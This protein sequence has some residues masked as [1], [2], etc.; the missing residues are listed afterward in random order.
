MD[1]DEIVDNAIDQM[2]K[3]LSA[4]AGIDL[5]NDER[6]EMREVLQDILDRREGR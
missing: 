3:K 1:I 4:C 6:D 2:D 5:D